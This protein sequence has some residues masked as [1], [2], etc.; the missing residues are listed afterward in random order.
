VKRRLLNLLTALSLLVCVAALWERSVDHITSVVLYRAPEPGGGAAGLSSAAGGLYFLSYS[1]SEG[2]KP[3]RFFDLETETLSPDPFGTP[4]AAFRRLPLKARPQHL[5]P[6]AADVHPRP[7]LVPARRGR[8]GLA[9]GHA[10]QASRQTGGPDDMTE[11][12]ISLWIFLTLFLFLPL[13]VVVGAH[14]AAG[15]GSTFSRQ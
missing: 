1:R 13:V 4:D 15:P 6:A 14:G 8:P 7:L 5:G 12:A 10:P 2:G 3:V 11:Y 9:L